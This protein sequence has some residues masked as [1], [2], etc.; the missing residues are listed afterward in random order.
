PFVGNAGNQAD[1]TIYQPSGSQ[2]VANQV[3]AVNN[4]V[5][6]SR[7]KSNYFIASST[8]LASSY[9]TSTSPAVVVITDSVLSL[10]NT[11]LSGFGVL[12]VPSGLEISNASLF[13]NGVV[14]VNSASGHVSVGSGAN[15]YINGALLLAP[16]AVFNF[17]NSSSLNASFR[18]SYSC[19]AVDLA[20]STLP[21]KVVSTAETSF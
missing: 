13:W 11:T 6:A 21:F 18:I 8:T 17:S 5:A 20:F 19:D 16:G 7:N 15:G 2:T 12:V 10:Q 9:G 14:L 4:L 3:A 1:T